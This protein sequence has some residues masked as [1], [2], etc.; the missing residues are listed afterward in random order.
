MSLRRP[1]NRSV[2][3]PVARAT[4]SVIEH[5]E[6]RTLLTVSLPYDIEFTGGESRTGVVDSNNVATGFEGVTADGQYV[7]SNVEVTGGTLKLTSTGSAAGTAAYDAN[8]TLVN[9]LVNGF[10]ATTG[11]FAITTR[12]VDLTGALAASNQQAGLW[13]GPD[14]DN[15]VK[16]VVTSSPSGPKLQFMDE[17][18]VGPAYIHTLTAGQSITALP[19]GS[20]ITALDLRMEGRYDAATGSAKII[21]YYKI[22][23]A[24]SFTKVDSELTFTGVVAD[25]FF[26][27]DSKAGILATHRSATTT[28]A[29]VSF[30]RF[31]ITAAAP[32]SGRPAVTAADPI[33]G[34]TN[35][36][37]DSRVGVRVAIPNNAG[38][39]TSTLTAD[40]VRLV[41]DSNGVAV[42][43]TLTI[44]AG[45]EE[46]FFTPTSRLA[47]NTTY[48]LFVTEILTDTN[49]NAFQPFSTSFT[50]GNTPADPNPTLAGKVTPS[51]QALVY[52]AEVGGAASAQ[53]T[54][55]VTN[56]GQ[57]ELVVGGVALA[58]TDAGQFTIVTNNAPATLAAGASFTVDVAFNPASGQTKG[59]KSAELQVIS[60]A[61]NLA[62]MSVA[63][64][65]LATTGSGGN[66]EP[67]LQRI[68]DLYDIP[69]NTGD[70]NAESTLLYSSGEPIASTTDEVTVQRL[71]RA[72]NGPVTIEALAAYAVPADLSVRLGYYSSANTQTKNELATLGG[73]NSQAIAPALNGATL[74]DPGTNPFSLY[75]TFPGNYNNIRFTNADGGGSGVSG[76][77]TARDVYSEDRLN[78]WDTNEDRKIR[79][80]PLKNADGTVVPNAYVFA[81]EEFTSDVDQ[82]DFV[83]IIRNVNI[84]PDAPQLGVS[85]PDGTVV[86][87][88]LTFSYILN[89]TPPANNGVQ[90]P[91][92]YIANTKTIKVFNTGTQPL[93]ISS[94][95]STSTRWQV[96]TP[97]LPVA[98][99]P[100]ESIDVTLVFATPDNANLY[101]G[102]LVI[103]SDDPISPT[104]TIN[105]RGLWQSLSENGQERLLRDVFGSF[106]TGTVLTNQGESIDTLGQRVATGDEILSNYWRS[107]DGG[108]VSVHQIAAFHAQGDRATMRVFSQ[109][110]ALASDG[111]GTPTGVFAVPPANLSFTGTGFRVSWTDNSTTETGFTIQRSVNGGA[112]SDLTTVAADA[113]SYNDSNL[114]FG[115]VYSYRVKAVAG[116]A[117]GA[118]SPFSEEVIG[119][120]L[121]THVVTD[122]QTVFPRRATTGGTQAVNFF[123]PTGNFGF[124]VDGEYS[125]NTLN[126]AGGVDVVADPHRFRFFPLKTTEGVTVPNTYVLIMDYRGINYDFNDNIYII[127]NIAPAE[128]IATPTRAGGYGDAA[129]GIILDWADN[130]EANLAGYN[131]YRAPAGSSTFTKLNSSAVTTSNY[132]D[133]SAA[134][135]TAYTYRL[136]AVVN[137]GDASFQNT[138]GTFTRPATETTAPDAPANLSG[139]AQSTRQ[140]L[141]NW[142]DVTSET[143]YTI[144][145]SIDGTSWTS[146]GTTAQG[147]TTSAVSDLQPGA[148]YQFRV[149]ATNG[150]GTSLASNVIS[151]TTLIDA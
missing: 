123:Q 112:F 90:P 39:E 132:T 130:T 52:S 117:G 145:R 140:V 134:V 126:T 49:G 119:Q 102:S 26:S 79:F 55:T 84:A 144:E 72:G 12:L 70:T 108:E 42:A 110:T 118:D 136:E 47:A 73:T 76:G 20:A 18:K 113:T 15:Y 105:L 148:T 5:L 16:L 78:T 107:A 33:A 48:T 125:D 114:S 106:N 28:P 124:A 149:L 51:A 57:S 127:S 120:S 34:A 58:G 146:V 9:N 65:G 7:A 25:R 31:D 22:N 99:Q 104:K 95:A 50:T 40:A 63:L 14:Q 60:N 36:N 85:N 89:T 75:A 45:G 19:T 21:A 23:N 61:S 17:R 131:V 35:I 37:R 77:G 43:G 98:I 142:N 82:N 133:A 29:V 135:G 30:D 46:I 32:L 6:G 103:Q 27:T 93:N 10:N 141:L 151:L 2:V 8:N 64:R 92:N 100:G 139:V 53:Q 129:A 91:N 83:G 96:T 128:G 56:T 4:R 41:R 62:T 88:T 97:T 11:D 143:G 80:Y 109:Q 74:F 24:A 38:I 150:A 121:L 86:P 67:S 87:D 147:V 71:V 59:I 94:I 54:L 81:I 13:F 137:G 3:S 115:S 69:V 101:T 116:G 68:L 1:K 44:A 111:S 138:I 122:G 66:N